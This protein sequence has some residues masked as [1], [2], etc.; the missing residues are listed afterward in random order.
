M[1]TSLLEDNSDT[2]TFLEENIFP[3]ISRGN[4]ILFLGAG[5]SVTDKKKYLGKEIINFYQ[6]KLTVDLET[7]DLVEFVDRASSLPKFSRYE[8]DQYI[9]EILSK[10]K[11][12]SFHTKITSLVWRQIITTNLDLILETAYNNIK[13]TFN[14]NKEIVP[15]RNIKEFNQSLSN[16]QIKYIKLNGCISDLSKYKFIFSTSDFLSNKKFYNAVIRNLSNLSNDVN[17][18]S[19]GYSFTDG[20]SKQLIDSLK[21]NN[22]QKEKVIFNIDPYPNKSLIPFYEENN[23]VTI[24]ITTD[25]FI[26][27]YNNWESNKLSRIVDKAKVKFYGNNDF[28]IFLDKKLLLRLKDKISQLNK[29]SNDIPISAESFYKGES[30]NY[31]IIKSDYDIIKKELNKKIT[32]AI[33]SSKTIDNLI[34]VNFIS[35]NY[36]IGKSTT[37]YRV[38]RELLDTHDYICFEILDPSDLKVQDLEELFLKCNTKNIILF[39]DTIERDSIFKEFMNLRLRLSSEQLPFNISFLAPIRENILKKYLRA[40]NYKNTNKIEVNHKLSD[41]EIHSLIKKL[42]LHNIINIRDKNEESDIFN[43]IKFKFESDPYI[44]LLSIV[45]NNKLDRILNDVI[46]LLPNEAKDA[47]FYTSLLYQ[48]K[49]PMPGSILKKLVSKDWNDFKNNVLEVDCKGLLINEIEAPI[50]TN[51]DLYFRTKHPIISEKT[52]ELVYKNK[53]KL[54]SEYLKIITLFNPSESH[55]KICVDLL[56]YIKRLKYF[57]TEKINKL[58]DEASK[59]F[60]INPNFNIHYAIDLEARNNLTLLINASDR[61]KYVDSLTEKRNTHIIHRRGVLDF[62][63]AKIYHKQNNSYLRDEY[64]DSAREFFHVKQVLDRFSSFSYYDYI[65]LELWVLKNIQKENEDIL[66][67]HTV[68]QDLF[69]KALYSVNENLEKIITLKNLYI[70]EIEKDSIAIFEIIKHFENLYDKVESRPYALIFKLNCIENKFFSFSNKL[71]P[72]YNEFDIVDELEDYSHLDS[73]K[74]SLF[75]FYSRRLY[76]INARI[77]LNSF[78]GDE[79]L[80]KDIFNYYFSFFIKESYDYQFS[81]ASNFLKEIQ[82][83]Y[84][85]LNHNVVEYWIDDETFKHR[86]FDGVINKVK[87]RFYIYVSKLGHKFKIEKDLSLELNDSEKYSCNLKFTSSGIFAFNLKKL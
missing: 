84:K 48:F 22:I 7:N 51:D 2:I 83:D 55:S 59:I 24:A 30:P 46:S 87:N 41:E 13:G 23:I 28:D 34:P 26:S 69:T 3:N 61:L 47:F 66:I 10:L 19:I 58:Y 81:H 70:K 76:D 67:Q 68:V 37:A 63:I 42:K 86:S 40:Y 85:F 11:P 4:T 71:L 17:F 72:N 79:F 29:F 8:F 60:E 50:D 75:N 82:K 56:K 20:L 31:S 6:E 14:E 65:N 52:I 53:E 77:K 44:A 36:G 25:K 9:K 21:K 45:E 16:D 73:V 15:V 64:I 33:L 57:D 12:D 74:E 49:I 5:F 27:Y 43:N 62:K 78:K 80:K 1:I 18:I 54:F 39:I 35:G 38:I 32:S